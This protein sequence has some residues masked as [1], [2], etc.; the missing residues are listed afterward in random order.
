MYSAYSSHAEY[1]YKPT[2][3]GKSLLCYKDNWM[4]RKKTKTKTPQLTVTIHLKLNPDP[5]LPCQDLRIHFRK[6]I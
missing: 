2:T 6:K 3:D 1:D 4:S 5:V